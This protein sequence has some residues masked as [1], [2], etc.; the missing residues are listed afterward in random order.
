MTLH[1]QI[2]AIQHLHS[3][4]RVGY[5]GRYVASSDHRI[6]IVACGYA[7]GYPRHAPTGTPVVVDGVLTH[8]LGTVS[9]DIIAVDLSLC[10]NANLGSPVELWGKNLPVDEVA[11]SAGT[12]G[13][14][15]LSALTPRVR[16][17]PV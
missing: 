1:S 14:E 2:I 8:T 10:P 5:S 16:K 12:L 7:D 9:M 4:N 13:Y 11:Q 15:L 17:Y 3:G 6:G